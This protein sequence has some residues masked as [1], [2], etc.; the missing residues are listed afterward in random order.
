MMP[1][2]D[3]FGFLDEFAKLPEE[4]TK[5]CKIVMLSTSESFKGETNRA[6]KNRYVYKFLN[7]P[8]TEQV[9]AAINV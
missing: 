1:M 3:G 8:L 6:N 5:K 2:M 7:K 9:L 4:I